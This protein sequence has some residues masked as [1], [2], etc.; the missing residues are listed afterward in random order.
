[1]YNRLRDTL[2]WFDHELQKGPRII[3]LGLHP[4]LIAVPHRIVYLEKMLDL[5]QERT[6]VIFMTGGQIADWFIN[7]HENESR[8]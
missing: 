2:Q 4:H 1:M 3:T 7:A 6:D 5:L 8:M